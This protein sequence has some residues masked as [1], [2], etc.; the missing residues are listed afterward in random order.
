M[1]FKKEDEL[2]NIIEILNVKYKER[3]DLLNKQ[4]YDENLD[5]EIDKI[6]DEKKELEL[7][8]FKN[9]HENQKYN[10]KYCINK[11]KCWNENCIFKHPL[12]WK[13]YNNKKDCIFCYKGFCNKINNKYKHIDEELGKLNVDTDIN[14]NEQIE[15]NNIILDE[16]EDQ[17]IKENNNTIELS[18]D[19]DE[20]KKQDNDCVDDYN[21]NSKLNKNDNEKIENEGV[22]EKCRNKLKEYENYIY[23]KDNKLELIPDIDIFL[24]K[25]YI[26]LD[27]SKKSLEML[28]DRYQ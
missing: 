23:I 12:N 25:L 24:E 8:I 28:L 13:P 21:I 18:I 27:N 2:N 5:K 19:I 10:K 20:L 15:K 6:E 7:I 17:N 3:D 11:D 26:D 16:K 4:I 1:K 22:I 9:T 14:K